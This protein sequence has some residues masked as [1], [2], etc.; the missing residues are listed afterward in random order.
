MLG[1][2][3]S[4]L[5]ETRFNC[6]L[7]FNS[8]L[9]ISRLL[10]RCFSTKQ[11]VI[12]NKQSFTVSY[13]IHTFGF[14]SN[15]AQLISKRVAFETPEKP[16]AMLNIFKDQELTD[17]T[18]SRIVR[19]R[20]QVLL[21]EPYKSILPKIEFLRS[22]GASSSDLSV[23]LGKDP[24]ILNRSLEKSLVPF[25]HLLKN[26][27]ISD[28]NVVTALKRS[29]FR[30]MISFHENLGVNLSLLAQI[31]IPQSSI[32]FCVTHY[33]A[34]L[35]MNADKFAALVKKVTDVGVDPSKL[36]FV[37]A[38]NVFKNLSDESWE[39]KMEVFRRWG[40]SEDEIWLMFRKHPWCMSKSEKSIMSKM[41]FLVIKMGRQPAEVARVPVVL[42][43]SLEKRIVPRCFV[44]RVLLLKGLINA[45]I[46]LSSLLIPSEELFLE[47]FIIK[48]QEEV[49]QLLDFFRGKVSFT[50]LGI[51]FD[52]KSEM[53][54]F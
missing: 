52:E 49:P 22:I 50:E 45:E 37:V 16:D 12:T 9:G 20:P 15:T 38:L 31:G 19:Y 10:I 42:C 18:I 5:V 32:S 40:L 1:F 54:N 14:P 28:D 13:L 6:L 43:C 44:S 34:V 36:A 2:C 48:Y 39:R 24:A 21:A 26:A 3:C 17:F 23:I 29:N 51:A 47:K 7:V 8:Q 27:G 53:L 41:S 11:N 4:R 46:P 30:S 25:Y 35:C 33:L